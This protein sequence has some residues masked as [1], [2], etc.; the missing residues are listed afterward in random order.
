MKPKSLILGIVNDNQIFRKFLTIH[1]SAGKLLS[2]ISWDFTKE[3]VGM[4]W[5]T[6]EI[7]V[8]VFQTGEFDLYNVWGDKV[9]Y[10]PPLFKQ[11]APPAQQVMACEIFENMLVLMTRDLSF[12]YVRNLSSSLNYKPEEIIRLGLSRPPTCFKTIPA[13]H[14]YSSSLEIFCGHPETG[15]LIIN[16]EQKTVRHHAKIPFLDERNCRIEDIALSASGEYLTLLLEG[17]NVVVLQSNLTQC[18]GVSL[19][20]QQGVPRQTVWCGDDAVCLVYSNYLMLYGPD[21]TTARMD[22]SRDKSGV[23]VVSELDGMRVFT[24]ETCEF[25][26]RVDESIVMIDDIAS[27][28]PPALLVTAYEAYS[29]HSSNSGD[30]IRRLQSEDKLQEAVENC[31]KAAAAELT[32]DKQAKWLKAANFGKAFMPPG[33]FDST[34]LVETVK[35]LK[36]LNNLRSPSVARPLTYRQLKQLRSNNEALIR[37]LL[38]THHHYLALQICRQMGLRQDNVYVHWACAKLADFSKE[39]SEMC[40]II[41]RKLN[42]CKSVSYTDIARKALDCNRKTLAIKLLENEPAI[43]RKVP[44]LI[45][46]GEFEIALDKAVESS[47]PDLIYLVLMRIHEAERV[48]RNDPDYRP[49]LSSAESRI[50]ARL[51]EVLN[52][53][54]AREMLLSYAK[55]IDE[56]LL[57]EAYK[58]LRRMQDAG[59]LSVEKAYKH[60]SLRLRLEFLESAYQLYRHY[61]KDPLFAAACKEQTTLFERQKKLKR[62]TNDSGLVGSTV[63]ETIARLIRINQETKADAFAKQFTVPEKKLW[64]IKLR[65]K[66]NAGD[67][68]G[69]EALARSKKNSPIGYKP[70]ADV[71]I[72]KGQIALAEQFILQA[73]DL[74]YQLPLLIHIE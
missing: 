43:S 20:E 24:T 14:S 47:D 36:V 72:K 42:A 48:R 17:R 13:D 18:R 9:V 4:G 34:V 57:K 59:H 15:L 65:V 31:I 7:L 55:Q 68:A 54:V 45:Y 73:N 35:H 26:Y 8:V 62:E 39:D 6:D 52:K 61:D 27:F 21:K 64:Y 11:P 69:V 67:W 32:Q 63:C 58:Y 3:F 40:E 41:C 56:D 19:V 70:F 49:N 51:E 28:L 29:E 16:C 22:C 74:D 5:T 12:Y 30:S 37:L 2:K 10:P 44:L 46:M 33:S 50:D 23:F 25:V 38:E 1:N 66:A 53:P 60:S 71:A